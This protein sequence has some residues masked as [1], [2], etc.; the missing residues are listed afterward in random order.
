MEPLDATEPELIE[1]V[2]VHRLTSAV[3]VMTVPLGGLDSLGFTGGVGES[4]PE[5]RRRAAGRLAHL[6]I[7][8]DAAAHAAAVLT[9]PAAPGA[10]TGAAAAAVQ[11]LIV[12]P[13]EDLQIAAG[14]GQAVARPWRPT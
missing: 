9:D 12:R 1:D 3:A 8:V 13:R 5:V 7:G 2:Y 14:V 4:A 10:E 11:T 6:G